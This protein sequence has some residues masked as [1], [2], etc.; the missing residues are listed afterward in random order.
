MKSNPSCRILPFIISHRGYSGLYAENTRA[1]FMYALDKGADGLEADFH[2]TQDGEVVAIHDF[3]IKRTSNAKG[4]VDELTL[5]QMRVLDYSSWKQGYLPAGY[6]RI[7]EQLMTL[8]EI[9]ELMLCFN[10]DIRFSLELKH[11]SPR[12][13][14]LEDAVMKVLLSYGYDPKTSEIRGVDNAVKVTLMSFSHD[15]LKHL[16]SVHKIPSKHLTALFH[17]HPDID[18]TWELEARKFAMRN[19][20]SI[21]GCGNT[22]VKENEEEIREW[23]KQGRTVSVWTVNTAD[24]ALYL[25]DL[26]VQSITTNYPAQIREALRHSYSS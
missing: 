7:D 26:G 4:K 10:R 18:K 6:G 22:Y 2:L 20:N 21:I 25:L 11:P 12:G 17:S 24:D 15:A 23:V 19:T 8:G 14:D 1:A 9:I 5:D 13:Q 3:D 16:K